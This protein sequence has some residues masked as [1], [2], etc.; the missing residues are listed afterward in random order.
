MSTKRS[1]RKMDE[2]L[3]MLMAHFGLDEVVVESDE[4]VVAESDEEV[5]AEEAESEGK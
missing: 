3:D 5:V 1:L 4:E 2:K